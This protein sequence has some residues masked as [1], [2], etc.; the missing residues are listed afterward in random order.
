MP[1][2]GAGAGDCT[3]AEAEGAAALLAP[4][5]PLC[6]WQFPCTG[7]ETQARQSCVRDTLSPRGPNSTPAQLSTCSPTQWPQRC[8]GSKGSH[9]RQVWEVSWRVGTG[10]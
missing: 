4:G 9:L 2:A 3:A 6:L 8:S 1:E 7:E 5:G 10:A